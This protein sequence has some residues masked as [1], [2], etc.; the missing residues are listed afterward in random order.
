LYFLKDIFHLSWLLI[1][2]LRQRLTTLANFTIQILLS[3]LVIAQTVITDF[4]S[5]SSCPKEVWR[6]ICSEVSIYFNLYG[7]SLLNL[8]FVV[9]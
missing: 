6:I 5:M 9:S 8:W 3:S 4:W 1:L 7:Y 2:L